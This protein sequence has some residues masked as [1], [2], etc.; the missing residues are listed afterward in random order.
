MT[1]RRNSSSMA[2]RGSQYH[3][4]QVSMLPDLSGMRCFYLFKINML[5]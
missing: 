4:V 2:R 5:W 1:K 3:E